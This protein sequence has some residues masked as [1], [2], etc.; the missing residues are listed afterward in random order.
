[1]MGPRL[2][3]LDPPHGAEEN[4]FISGTGEIR[5]VLRDVARSGARAAAYFDGDKRFIH[6]SLLGVTTFPARVVFEKGPDAMLNARLLEADR[7]TIVTSHENV[8]VQFSCGAPSLTRHE[9]TEAFR[10]PLPDSVLRLQRRGY[11]RLPGE[12]THALLKCELVPNHDDTHLIRA[13]VFDLSCGGIGAAVAAAEPGLTVGSVH[14]CHLELPGYGSVRAP[15]VVRMVA[16]IV[17][18]NALRGTRYGLEFENLAEAGR[19]AIER[20]IVEHRGREGR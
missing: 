13:A 14:G 4:C 5:S 3:L 10:V 18:P 20:Y 1:M 15:V 2:K 19:E 12:P 6:T 7:V 17:L 9:G 8:P 11:Y 16:E